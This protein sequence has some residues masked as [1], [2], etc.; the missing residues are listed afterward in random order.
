MKTAMGHRILRIALGL[1]VL[2]LPL[3]FCGCES[4]DTDTDIS[5]TRF[6]VDSELWNYSE[7]DEYTWQTTLDRAVV[8]VR[9]DDFTEG[10]VG[11]RIYDG[12]GE[13]VFVSALNTLN[14]VYYNG[15]DYF[16]QRQTDPGVAGLWRIVL[17]YNDFTGKF[18]LTLE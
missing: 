10:D 6:N 7:T 4:D 8:I 5:A 14:S 18:D 13:L 17:D 11:V 15:E 1:A 9:I 16:F 3:A 12:A 2:A